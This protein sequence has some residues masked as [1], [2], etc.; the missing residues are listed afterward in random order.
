MAI[1]ASPKIVI[2][3]AGTVG[4]YTGGTLA[5]AGR[6]VTLL[7]RPAVADE[8]AARGFS[9]R[10]LQNAE[11]FVSPAQIE[12]SADPAI[13]FNGAGV[14]IVTVKCRAT[15][16]MA[17]LIGRHAQASSTVV[18]F[19]NG[20]D[21]VRILRDRLGSAQTVVAGMV[22]FN[23]MQMPRASQ[24]LLFLR[25]TSGTIQIEAGH[26]G[27]RELLAVSGLPVS[28]NPDMTGVLWSKLVIN[29]NNAIN[30]LA[31]IALRSELRDPRWRLIL[32]R[33]MEEALATLKAAGIPT[34]PIEGVQ[35]H[36]MA[37]ALRLPTWLFRI[38]AA[39]ALAIDPEA[40]SSMWDDLERG[41][42]TE[43]E[44]LQGAILRLALEHGVAAPLTRRIS[45]LIRQS[46]LAGVGSPRLDPSAFGTG[47]GKRP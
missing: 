35:P 3:G 43:I 41:R 42:P 44:Y 27:I 2:A 9:V 33:Q 16:D 10:D 38:V 17:D 4:C 28:E 14:I 34:R 18:S 15:A 37:K 30:A 26:C 23:V 12:L 29:L 22:P 31:G 45:E 20:V 25:A 19:Q 32:A 21:N 36:V 6:A 5:L 8:I 39:Q 7:L 46:E 40:R 13:A 1:A 24:P 47:G 11:R